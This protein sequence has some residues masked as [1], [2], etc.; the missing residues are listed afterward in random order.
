MDVRCLTSSQCLPSLY[1]LV[2][3]IYYIYTCIAGIAR[4]TK[5]C[6]RGVWALSF[7]H[8][9]STILTAY[10]SGRDF[11]GII[12]LTLERSDKFRT[13]MHNTLP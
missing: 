6:D 4:E 13:E 12:T 9:Q 10:R 7:F 2:E 5:S 11:C 1:L 3:N 8:Y